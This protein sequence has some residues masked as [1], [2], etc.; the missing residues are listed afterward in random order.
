MPYSWYEV[1]S[2]EEV[3]ITE[4][5]SKSKI[6]NFIYRSLLK[7][8]TSSPI[9]SQEKWLRDLQVENISGIHWKEAYTIVFNCTASTKLR[10]FH[11]KFL[12]RRI[13]TFLFGS[14]LF[15]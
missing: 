10:T 7:K 2:T 3:T 12:H 15:G 5:K 9:G 11:F 4:L 1:D 13:T 8:I 14:L 6:N